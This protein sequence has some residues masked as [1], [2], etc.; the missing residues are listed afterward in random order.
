[1]SGLSHDV[2][3]S[4]N[5]KSPM[6]GILAV[7]FIPTENSGGRICHA[8]LCS[9][10]HPPGTTIDQQGGG[11]RSG[12]VFRP[13]S[14]FQ[15]FSLPG[16]L[17]CFWLPTCLHHG[18]KMTQGNAT[19]CVGCAVMPIKWPVWRLKDKTSRGTRSKEKGP[20]ERN[21]GALCSTWCYPLER[22]RKP[23]ATPARNAALI[24][25]NKMVVGSFALLILSW[26]SS[27]YSL[28]VISKRAF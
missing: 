14:I 20:L 12:K 18:L 19:Y 3:F 1:M 2:T 6:G 9:L 23:I 8:A 21:L 5:R 16:P 15:T 25:S 26:S 13:R 28:R 27:S 7:L 11:N 17:L 10:K 4:R 24:P 22:I